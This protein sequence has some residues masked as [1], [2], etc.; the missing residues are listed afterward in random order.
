MIQEI[1]PYCYGE[2]SGSNEETRSFYSG[3]SSNSTQENVSLTINQSFIYQTGDQLKTY[4]YI[5]R[6]QTY[7]SGGY[8]YEFRDSLDQLREDLA[9]LH[10]LGWID[11]QTRAILIQMSL[12]NPSIPLFTPATLVVEFLPSSGV[13]PSARIEPL[14]FDGKHSLNDSPLSTIFF[15]SAF[16]SKFQIAC[17]II[18]LIFIGYFMIMEITSFIRLKKAHFLQFWSYIELGIIVCSWT[19]VGIHIW[20]K[21]E[22]ARLSQ[23][24]RTT[25]GDSYINFQL[26]AY[27]HDIFSFLLGFCCFFGTL[28]FLRLCRYNR[29]LALLSETLR[30]SRRELFSFSFMFATIFMAFL[31]LFYLQF[32]SLVWS[33]SSLLH[34]AQMLFEMLIL[35]FNTSELADAAPLLGPLYFTFFIIFVVFVC[36]NMFVSIVNDNFRLARADVHRVDEDNQDVFINFLK[37]LQRW[38]GKL[39]SLLKKNEIMITN[40]FSGDEEPVIS[41]VRVIHV[42]EMMAPIQRL[43]ERLDRLMLFVDRVCPNIDV[44]S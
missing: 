41:Q 23:L 25:R 16:N 43:S 21:N 2:Y 17:G 37:K 30:R 32:N 36:I 8:V 5:G 39:I 35:K 33:C 15:S 12:F 27:I 31:V 18:Y 40:C 42:T 1:I 3:W 14:D 10:R 26:V 34:T 4:F 19:G 24:F 9:E 44:Q 28:K 6:H 38:F 22:A 7:R 29:R 20:R 11:R 13:Y